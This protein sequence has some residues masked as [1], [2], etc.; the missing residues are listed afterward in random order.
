ML[1]HATRSPRY[2]FK[3]PPYY[4]LVVRSL[5][6]LEGIAL[7]VDPDFEIVQAAV[8]QALYIILNSHASFSASPSPPSPQ[9]QQQEEDRSS[10]M[11]AF[12]L[13]PAGLLR[14]DVVTTVLEALLR[15]ANQPT[16]RMKRLGA[17]SSPSSPSSSS[18]LLGKWFDVFRSASAALRTKPLALAHFWLISLRTVAGMLL[19]RAREKLTRA[20]RPT[21]G[22]TVKQDRPP[23]VSY[24]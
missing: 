10:L 4:I 3:L 7:R 18:S 11:D 15:D 1:Q 9:Q 12:L 17:P 21:S 8:P 13:T 22:K 5:A 20:F 19:A 16:N 14:E 6:T 23:L 24:S 2:K